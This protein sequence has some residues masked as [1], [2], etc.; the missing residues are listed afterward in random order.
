M[1]Y[2]GAQEQTKEE[3]AGALQIDGFTLDEVNQTHYPCRKA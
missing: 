1:T 2:N 3:I